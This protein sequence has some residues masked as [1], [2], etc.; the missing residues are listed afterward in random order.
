MMTEGT[1]SETPGRSRCESFCVKVRVPLEVSR[2][3]KNNERRRAAKAPRGRL[4]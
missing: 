3:W 4:M 1:K 2:G